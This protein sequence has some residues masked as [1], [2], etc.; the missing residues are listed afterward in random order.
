MK[1]FLKEQKPDPVKVCGNVSAGFHTPNPERI[2]GYEGTCLFSLADV[3][4]SDAIAAAIEKNAEL[5][6]EL[7]DMLKR[8]HGDDYG[9]VTALE[10]DANAVIRYFSFSSIWMIARYKHDPQAIVFETLYDMCLFYFIDEDV[11]DV[12]TE[13][14]ETFCKECHLR[15]VTLSDYRT[16]QLR[17]EERPCS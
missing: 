12:A 3:Y 4:V 5:S 10:D 17:Y 15:N 1:I 7:K 13:Q 16:N 14:F 9:F 8:F 6:D 2:N 11:T